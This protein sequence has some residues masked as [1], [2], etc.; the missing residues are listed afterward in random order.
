MAKKGSKKT[1][2]VITTSKQQMRGSISREL[3]HQVMVSGG[4]LGLTK[5]DILQ[6]ALLEWLRANAE[7]TEEAIRR[8]AESL[9]IS[10]QEVISG[11]RDYYEEASR[12]HRTRFEDEDEDE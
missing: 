7:V 12:S 4:I 5:A 2:K 10:E 3:Y 9:G 11:I 1:E 6:S 8:K